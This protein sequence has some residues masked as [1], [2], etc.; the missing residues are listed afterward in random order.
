MVHHD[1]REAVG[2]YVRDQEAVVETGIAFCGG[3]EGERGVV[4]GTRVAAYL[5]EQRFV[6]AGWESIICVFDC[7]GERGMYG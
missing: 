4:E 1:D 6:C 3:E 2:R 7:G 5:K